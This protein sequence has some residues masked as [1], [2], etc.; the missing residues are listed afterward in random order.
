VRAS[1]GERDFLE[2]DSIKGR[3]KIPPRAPSKGKSAEATA[4]K[5][6]FL[7]TP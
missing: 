5:N 6:T 4:K 3:D 7:W 1:L 2:R